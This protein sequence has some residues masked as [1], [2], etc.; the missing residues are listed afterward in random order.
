VIV[1]P[2]IDLRDGACVQLVGGD[3]AEERV[4]LDDPIAIAVQ[5]AELGFAA[6]HVVDL[7]AAV[8]RGDNSSI[9]AE[10]I[11][12]VGVPIQVGGG[13]R[14]DA[15]LDRLLSLGAERV[16]AGTRALEDP[17]W[18]ERAA[19]RLP[20]R[21]VVA[22]DVRDRDV[23]THGW[24]RVHPEPFGVVMERLSG[25][26]LAG[27]LVTAVHQEGRMTGPDL[28]LSREAAALVPHPMYASGGISGVVDLRALATTSVA[29]AVIGM[30]LYTGALD[31][32]QAALEFGGAARTGT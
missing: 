5:W 7:D 26:P 12:A 17:D 20:G 2:A 6:L 1:I 15:A 23:L 4:R 24:T 16:V 28:D 13:V 10:M 32:R 8:G 30:A 19:L 31:A 14:D 18:L 11:G 25:L 27:V 21:I 9:V 3:Y 29:G 22:A